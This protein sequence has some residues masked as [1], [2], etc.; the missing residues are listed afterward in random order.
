MS[1]LYLVCALCGRKQAEGLL[2]RGAWGHVELEGGGS[3]RACPQCKGAHS[4]WERR[5][6]ATSGGR[7][8]AVYAPEGEGD[9]TGR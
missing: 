2:S 8:G 4:D 6:V 1:P 7:M 9:L 5:V 3:L